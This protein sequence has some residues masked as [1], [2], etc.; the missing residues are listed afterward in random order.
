M[1][2]TA[3]VLFVIP[4]LLACA[5]IGGLLGMIGGDPFW[6]GFVAGQTDLQSWRSIEA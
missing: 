5:A 4:A 6:E 3:L 1:D 2:T